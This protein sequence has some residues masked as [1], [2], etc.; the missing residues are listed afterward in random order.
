[1]KKG[2]Q[3]LH[4]HRPEPVALLK[5][6]DANSDLPS[7]DLKIGVEGV[8]FQ[9]GRK[10]SQFVEA[11]AQS[12]VNRN[13]AVEAGSAILR[14]RSAPVAT[15]ADPSPVQ[16]L[17]EAWQR[18]AATYSVTIV[19]FVVISI[20]DDSHRT[21]LV[22]GAVGPQSCSSPS[23]TWKSQEEASKQEGAGK[24]VVV[25]NETPLFSTAMVRIDTTA[26]WSF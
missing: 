26:P 23:T 10:V 13:M 16:Y 21:G 1:M 6:M 25:Q 24:Q 11:G 14:A 3:V 5:V 17:D 8:S 9:P 12:E 2:L 7:R 15:V 4:Q 20:V 19:S 22:A 18:Q